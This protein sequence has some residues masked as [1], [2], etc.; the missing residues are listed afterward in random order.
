MKFIII[1]ITLIFFMLLNQRKIFVKSFAI[2]IHDSDTLNEVKPNYC[3]N[4]TLQKE[5]G[6]TRTVIGNFL[7]L[8]C[9]GEFY[10]CRTYSD[11][12][13]TFKKTCTSGLVFD[14]HGSQTCNYDYNVIGC[15]I[16]GS[17]IKLCNDDE[18]TCSMSEQCVKIGKRCDGKYDCVLEEDE[19]NCP[20]CGKNEFQCVVSEECLP[21][22]VR[23]NGI[24]ECKD[25]TDELNCDQCGSGNFFCRN[26]NQC[27]PEEMRC[28]G[29]RHCSFG[30][31][32][33]NCRKNKKN[34]KVYAC[35]DGSGKIDMKYVCDGVPDCQDSSDENYCEETTPSNIYHQPTYSNYIEEVGNQLFTRT[36]LFPISKMPLP[37]TTNNFYPQPQPITP[38][39]TKKL[40]KKSKKTKSLTTLITST[41]TTTLNSL[42]ESIASPDNQ[43]Y[44]NTQDNFNKEV[45]EIMNNHPSFTPNIPE[46]VGTR[47]RKS[48]F[49]SILSTINPNII[50]NAI[51]SEIT[52]N[53]VYNENDDLL[54]KLTLKLNSLDNQNEVNNLLFKLESLLSPS[55]T[56]SNPISYSSIKLPSKQNKIERRKE[57]LRITSNPL[58]K[59]KPSLS[60]HNN[61]HTPKNIMKDRPLLIMTTTT[62]TTP[63]PTLNRIDVQL[64]Q[65]DEP[66]IIDSNEDKE[67]IEFIGIST[68]P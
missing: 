38:K 62:T 50:E 58:R 66:M 40:N 42:S 1:S 26:S 57:F 27:I 39:S 18:F 2:D 14:T 61:R 51:Q 37:L 54:K 7:G 41:S 45:P 52:T 56:T 23:C 43:E 32:E 46:F 6:L 17:K 44:Q 36:P 5:Y 29:M 15:G 47:G 13:K 19:Q 49:N 60:Q 68:Q 55:T 53:S 24:A 64:R 9:S 48:F 31:D 33:Y 34:P 10:Q 28:D 11:G 30:E 59:W 12:Y 35:E 25:K 8:D 63:F 65:S 4:I 67:S 22:N 20:M 16:R 21:Q 3:N